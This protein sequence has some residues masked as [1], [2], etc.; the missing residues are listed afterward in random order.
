MTLQTMLS[1]F[2]GR[3]VE[4]VVANAMYEGTLTSVQTGSIKV[5]E[6]PIVYS[7]PIVVTIPTT[8]LEYV[9]VMAL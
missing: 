3:T 6:P 4:V 1:S 2:I 9:R 8:A 7:P 5:A